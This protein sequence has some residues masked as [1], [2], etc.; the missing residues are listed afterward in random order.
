MT[1]Y[2]VER[3]WLLSYHTTKGYWMNFF[4]EESVVERNCWICGAQ[5]SRHSSVFA[6]CFKQHNFN[7]NY[8]NYPNFHTFFVFYF[9]EW[10]WKS[11]K[12]R[13]TL[14]FNFSKYVL[15][16]PL[17]KYTKVLFN[18]H[19]SLHKKTNNCP[20][21]FFTITKTIKKNRMERQNSKIR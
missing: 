3:F 7:P 10:P 11:T 2:L 9:C 20:H 15:S 19:C 4:Y 21:F 14:I 17:E 8:P 12:E 5:V 18:I 13:R 16:L 6:V 1:T